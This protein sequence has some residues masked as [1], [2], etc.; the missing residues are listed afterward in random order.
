M[1]GNIVETSTEFSSCLERVLTHCLFISLIKRCGGGCSR[2]VNLILYSP[3]NNKR[4]L[5]HV[6]ISL[7][8]T[9]RA[10]CESNKYFISNYSSVCG[11]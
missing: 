3:A 8:I 7:K 11:V 9:K 1:T 5:M 4:D 10:F 2:F 6:F